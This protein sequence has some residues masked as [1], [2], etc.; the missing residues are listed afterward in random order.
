MSIDD[1]LNNLDAKKK[2]QVEKARKE[3]E[4]KEMLTKKAENYISEFNQYYVE[5][6]LPEFQAIG[7]KLVDRF[8]VEIDKETVVQQGLTN[9]ARIIL[10]SKFDNGFKKFEI[11]VIGEGRRELITLV[12]YP[13]TVNDSRIDSRT[14]STF[15]DTMIEFKKLNLETEIGGILT[16]LYI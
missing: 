15:Q 8:E 12:A 9:Q 16:Q 4:E 11:V 14:I 3:Q 13:Y 5:R 1:F 2:A 10:K 6:I 7:E